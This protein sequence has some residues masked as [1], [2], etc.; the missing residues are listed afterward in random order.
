MSVEDAPADRQ[1]SP[2]QG[3]KTKHICQHCNRSVSHDFVRVYGDENGEVHRCFECATGR[4]ISR[5]LA[6]DPDRDISL[7]DMPGGSL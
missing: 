6:T 2:L 1:W 3:K 7:P 4:E 5:G